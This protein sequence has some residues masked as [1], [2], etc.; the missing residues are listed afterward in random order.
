M[1]LPPSWFSCVCLFFSLSPQ[2]C[3]PMAVGSAL[4]LAW[5][6]RVSGVGRPRIR[7]ARRWVLRRWEARPGGGMRRGRP[8]PRGFS[9]TGDASTSREK[10]ESRRA[11]QLNRASELLQTIIDEVSREHFIDTAALIIEDDEADGLD[12]ASG[13]GTEALAQVARKVCRVYM[14]ELDSVFLATLLA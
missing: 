7:G 10:E 8:A 4:R 11:K 3:F 5:E 6:S 2:K 13:K 1:R 9:G 12:D 14:D